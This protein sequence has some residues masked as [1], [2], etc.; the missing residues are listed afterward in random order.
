VRSLPAVLP[1]GTIVHAVS[2]PARDDLTHSTCNLERTA[3]GTPPE[4]IENRLP[5]GRVRL[6]HAML[7]RELTRRSELEAPY[8]HRVPP[9]RD[10]GCG[11]RV[12]R[13]P[14]PGARGGELLSLADHR[15]SAVDADV[16]LSPR[17]SVP[18]RSEQPR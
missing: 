9:D 17:G 8:D 2:G 12:L 6:A 11:D 1:R 3:R 10:A 18:D 7:P 16:V 4:V 13:T 14:E 5:D 15:A